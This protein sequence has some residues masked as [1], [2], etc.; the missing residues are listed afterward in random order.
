M[1]NRSKIIIAVG[2]LL[3]VLCLINDYR[4]NRP[5]LTILF[6]SK[7]LVNTEVTGADDI[8][9][10]ITDV[11]G[12]LVSKGYR[13][14]G[15]QVFVPHPDG[16]AIFI[17]FPRSGHKTI[18]IYDR[19]STSATSHFYLGF[20]SSTEISESFSFNDEEMALIKSGKN[21]IDEV[22]AKVLQEIH[23]E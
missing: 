21:T 4:C 8:L 18:D 3:L 2:L 11:N 13:K 17:S 20:I 6:N 19:Y 15:Q 16:G 10:D 7:A 9:S 1:K 23:Q 5:T 14:A 12:T 22:E